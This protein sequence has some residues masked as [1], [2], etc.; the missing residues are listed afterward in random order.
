MLNHSTTPTVHPA[1]HS[2]K[3]PLDHQI[4]HFQRLLCM[5]DVFL[6]NMQLRTQHSRLVWMNPINGNQLEF[7][8]QIISPA[9]LCC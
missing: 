1:H 5:H 2:G 4:V 8:P 6:C 9:H 7:G 3:I